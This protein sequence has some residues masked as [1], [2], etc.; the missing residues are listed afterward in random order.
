MN[1]RMGEVITMVLSKALAA[2]GTEDFQAVFKQEVQDLGTGALPL[3]AGMAYSSHVSG[4][5]MTVVVLAVEETP[6]ALQVRTGIFYAGVIAGS[7][8]ADDPSPVCEQPEY[9]E[10]RFDIDKASAGATAV[11]LA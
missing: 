9:C 5:E 2:W 7:C 1:E 8:C 6:T 3:Q 4:D 10:L 11:L